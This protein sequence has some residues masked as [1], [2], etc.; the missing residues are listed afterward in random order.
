MVDK[1]SRS[2]KLLIYRRMKK[3]R[4]ENKTTKLS[5]SAALLLNFLKL[6]NLRDEAYS[7]VVRDK[8]VAYLRK[9]LGNFFF[10]IFFMDQIWVII[11]DIKITKYMHNY[12]IYMQQ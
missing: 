7:E 1:A 6:T 5:F 12:I 9:K 11:L 3:K 4:K 2:K 10:Q 8:F